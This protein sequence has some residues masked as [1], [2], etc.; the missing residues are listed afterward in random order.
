M[1]DTNVP[2]APEMR[3]T[4]VTTSKYKTMTLSECAKFDL[5]NHARETLTGWGAICKDRAAKGLSR[6][7]NGRRSR[8]G[9]GA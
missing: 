2:D 3:L 9:T 8:K 7:G 6:R 1:T 5:E 4:D